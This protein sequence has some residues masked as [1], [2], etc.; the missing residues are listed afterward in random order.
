MPELGTFRFRLLLY[1]A[2]VSLTNSNLFTT[3]KDLLKISTKYVLTAVDWFHLT[4]NLPAVRNQ[5]HWKTIGSMVKSCKFY[6]SP[7]VLILLHILIFLKCFTLISYYTLPAHKLLSTL[8]YHHSARV[9]LPS[10]KFT[11]RRSIVSPI[12]NM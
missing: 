4:S 12:Y 2:I 7:Q 1:M 8:G 5:T 11:I 9:L 3:Y 6:S 10:K